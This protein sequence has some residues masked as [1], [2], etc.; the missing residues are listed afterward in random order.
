MGRSTASKPLR[1]WQLLVMAS[2]CLLYLA[3]V[4]AV[5]GAMAWWDG[6]IGVVLGLFIC[7]LPVHHFLDLLIYW[8]IEEARFR[9]RGA[10]P[11][12]IAGNAVVLA[13]G[14][15]VIVVG[16]TRFSAAR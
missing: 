3:L 5:G 10:L 2:L 9:K 7:S 12:W 13:A 1:A 8:R 15:L 16:V 6:V 4:T 14:W 11:W